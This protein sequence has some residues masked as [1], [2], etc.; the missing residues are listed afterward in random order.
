VNIAINDIEMKE[1]VSKI[2]QDIKNKILMK[3][4]DKK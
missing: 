1:L 4:G 2:V 3:G